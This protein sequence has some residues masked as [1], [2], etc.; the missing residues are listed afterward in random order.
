[1]AKR[2]Y[3]AMG[4]SFEMY[5]VTL[6]EDISIA[7]RDGFSL[8]VTPIYLYDC[9]SKCTNI[10]RPIRSYAVDHLHMNAQLRNSSPSLSPPSRHLNSSKNIWKSTKYKRLIFIDETS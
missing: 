4:E 1:M 2:E 5:F 3:A 9:M 10:F 7:V 8:R 6:V